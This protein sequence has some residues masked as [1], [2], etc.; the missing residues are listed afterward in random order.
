[1]PWTAPLSRPVRP[2]GRTPLRSLAEARA[3]LLTLPPAEAARPAWQTA[4]GLLITAAEAGT[5]AATEEA[6]AQLERAL[7]IGYRLDM[8]G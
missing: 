2:R 8:T 6:T 3:Y 1:M 7:F 4:A 5:M